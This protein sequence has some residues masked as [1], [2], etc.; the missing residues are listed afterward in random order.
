MMR[1]ALFLEKKDSSTKIVGA[2]QNSQLG[3]ENE[4]FDNSKKA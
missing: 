2:L 4:T 3:I 1:I